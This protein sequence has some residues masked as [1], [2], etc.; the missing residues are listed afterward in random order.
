MGALAGKPVE[1]PQLGWTSGRLGAPRVNLE[2]PDALHA[3]LDAE[4]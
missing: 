3:L 4:R 1:S 2:D